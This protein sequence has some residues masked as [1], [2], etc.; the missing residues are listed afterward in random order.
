MQMPSPPQ[1]GPFRVLIWVA[2]AESSTPRFYSISFRNRGLAKPLPRPPNSSRSNAE[3]P[4]AHP[5]SWAERGFGAE[6]LITLTVYLKVDVNGRGEDVQLLSGKQFGPAI[7]GW[8]GRPL[9]WR[10]A[11]SSSSVCSHP[12]HVS[13]A[14]P[15]LLAF[16]T[17]NV[18][19][20]PGGIHAG[21]GN[22]GD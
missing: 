1:P 5:L 11:I 22:T 3:R 16:S 7:I 20:S 10:I 17:V 13:H 18:N 8:A 19:V 2:G 4:S 21:D 9:D 12:D 6:G 14:V 15:Q